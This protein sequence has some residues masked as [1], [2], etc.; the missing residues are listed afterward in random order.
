MA[1]SKA[2]VNITTDTT[3][4]QNLSIKD[5]IEARDNFHIHLMKKENV[6]GTA[7]GKYRVRDVDLD[8]DRIKVKRR[9]PRPKRT[10]QTSR[11]VAES[12]PCI[13]VFVSD[14]I[15][16]KK[17]KEGYDFDK[18]IPTKVYMPDG[19]EVPICVIEAPRVEA[20]WIT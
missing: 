14:W 1:T 20:V 17:L 4:Y 6:V 8:G 12:W 10:L 9:Y 18:I 19:R 13:L 15:A 5:L 3:S 2:A 7:I 11:I 16:D